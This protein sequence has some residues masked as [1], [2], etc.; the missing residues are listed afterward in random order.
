MN[1]I[2]L[3]GGMSSRVDCSASIPQIVLQGRTVYMAGL[4]L[5]SCQAEL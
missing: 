3:L 4:P 2:P 1:D 5:A